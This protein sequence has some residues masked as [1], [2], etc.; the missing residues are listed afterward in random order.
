MDGT[1]IITV[2]AAVVGLT[3]ILKWSSLPT[4]GLIPVVLVFVLSALGVILWGVSTEIVFDRHLLWP[5]FAGWVAVS[6][7]AAGVFGLAQSTPKAFGSGGR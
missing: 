3:Q 6:T 5:Y 4:S 2:S 7:S 1:A